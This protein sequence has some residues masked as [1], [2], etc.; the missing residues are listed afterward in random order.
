M[1]ISNK[2]GFK[3]VPDTN[4]IIASKRNPSKESPNVEFIDRWEKGDFVILYSYDTVDEYVK[5]MIDRGIERELIKKFLKILVIA[6][7]QIYIDTFHEHYY[8]QD[9]KDIPF[10]LCC[11]NGKG[12][13]I[14]SYDKHLL[15]L[16]GKYEFDI[17]K[18][19]DFLKILRSAIKD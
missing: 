11:I 8:P 7:E 15:D 2:S 14:V 18:V 1:T 9:T 12:T 3:V 4:V 13:H 5:K 10:I 16:E 17:L 6:G 19:I